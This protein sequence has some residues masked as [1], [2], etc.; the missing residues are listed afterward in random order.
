MYVTA[1]LD[2]GVPGFLVEVTILPRHRE[3]VKSNVYLSAGR[4]VDI[5]VKEVFSIQ[6]SREDTL[7]NSLLIAVRPM[8]SRIMLYA[9]T[10]LNDLSLTHDNEVML[11]GNLKSL[12]V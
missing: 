10:E 2:P 8:F 1:T 3:S 6:C 11:G 4:E 5:E 12:A 9:E 7:T